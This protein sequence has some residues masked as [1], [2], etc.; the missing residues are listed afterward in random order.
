MAV[1]PEGYMYHDKSSGT[2]YSPG[3]TMP[4]SEEGDQLYIPG[5]DDYNLSYVFHDAFSVSMHYRGSYSGDEYPDEYKTIYFPSGWS[6]LNLSYTCTS[7]TPFENINGYPVVRFYNDVED[8]AIQTLT[9]HTNLVQ[10]VVSTDIMYLNS[11]DALPIETINGSVG[12][13]LKQLFFRGCFNLK[14]INV[15]LSAATGLVFGKDAFAG[16]RR[17]VSLST[18]PPNI[19]VTT[20][21]FLSCTQLR[22]PPAIP[23]KVKYADSMFRECTNLTDAPV[24]LSNQVQTFASCFHSCNKLVSA[25]NIVFPETLTDLSRMFYRCSV[26]TGTLQTVHGTDCDADS[27]FEQCSSLVSTPDFNGTFTSFDRTFSECS[28]LTNISTIPVSVTSMVRTFQHCTSLTTLPRVLRGK[29]NYSYCFSGC[30]G[31]TDVSMI[32]GIRTGYDVQHTFVGM[33]WGCSNLTGIITINAAHRVYSPR[34]DVTN[35]FNNT[36]KDIVVDW[37][38]DFN[39]LGAAILSESGSNIHHGVDVSI[40][41]TSAVRCDE[42]GQMDDEGEYCKLTIS[43]NCPVIDK[44][45]I[46]VPKVYI[47]NSQQEPIVDWTLEYTNDQEEIITK[48]IQNS[49]SIVEERI[50]ANA[51]VSSGIFYTIFDADDDGSE[52]QISI[53]ASCDDVPYDFDTNWNILYDTRYWNGTVGQAIFTGTTYIWDALPDGSSFKIGGPIQEDDNETGF[54][55]G[56]PNIKSEKEQYPSTFNGPVSF[57]SSVYFNYNETISQMDIRGLLIIGEIRQYAGETAPSGWLLCDGSAI[58]RIT[59]SELFEVI[60]TTYG[61]GNGSTTFNIPDMRGRVGIGS[62]SSYEL[63]DTGGEY[64]HL[65]TVDEMPSHTHAIGYRTQG[66]HNGSMW[67]V[68]PGTITAYA[69]NNCVSARGGSQAHNNMQP[70]VAIN[71]IIFSGVI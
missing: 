6:V 11:Q 44:S 14:N 7:A 20:N 51:A 64:T 61:E 38:S 52:Y 15:D 8:S 18:I 27:M 71:F 26:L 5:A 29:T 40:M 49:T 35:M 2:Y 32:I 23:S 21:M 45:K 56:N 53:E 19:E 16:C 36:Q 66:N 30:T 47:K 13:N 3:D 22:T 1:V 70:Y 54:I 43:F 12:S 10:V 67:V 33:F 28:S 48:V 68:D 9:L 50:E 34:F 17:L 58:N 24:N 39:Q 57:N 4:A 25:N 37:G 65:L 59:Y 42:T 31:L 62:S 46:Y 63:G 60:G 41:D 55:V 69:D